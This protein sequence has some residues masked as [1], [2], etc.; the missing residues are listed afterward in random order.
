MTLVTTTYQKG[1]TL[2]TAAM[3]EVE[4]CL[5]RLPGLEKWFIDIA[6]APVG[7]RESELTGSPLTGG[8]AGLLAGIPM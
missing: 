8:T 3:A 1:V 6:P 2:T 5:T 7:S 4:A